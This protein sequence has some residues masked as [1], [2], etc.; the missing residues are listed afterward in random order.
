M[1]L[2]SKK[3]VTKRNGPSFQRGRRPRVTRPGAVDA[4]I[5]RQQF[6]VRSK[7]QTKPHKSTVSKL[8][9]KRKIPGGMRYISRD[10]HACFW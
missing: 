2:S 5:F 7:V 4:M 8:L 10:F 9:A 1:A 6:L 3:V